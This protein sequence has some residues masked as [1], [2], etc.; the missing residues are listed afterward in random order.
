MKHLREIT[1]ILRPKV[2]GLAV[3]NRTGDEEGA[4][5][6]LLYLR[7]VS[8]WGKKGKNVLF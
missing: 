7:F 1:M 2:E 4:A 8:I 6:N 5:A 3:F